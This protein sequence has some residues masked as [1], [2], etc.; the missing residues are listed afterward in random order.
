MT[1]SRIDDVSAEPMQPKKGTRRRKSKDPLSYIVD[2][3][4]GGQDEDNGNILA[5][6]RHGRNVLV[7]KYHDQIND[8]IYRMRLLGLTIPQICGVLDVRED[9]YKE[10]LQKYPEAKKAHERGGLLAD[11]AVAHA[12]F[13]RAT[14]YS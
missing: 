13:H 14:G 7:R 2:V 8:Y 5:Y 4:E 6:H 3:P 1:R 12:L 9:T 10:W 11:A